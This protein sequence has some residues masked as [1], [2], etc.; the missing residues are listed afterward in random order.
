MP[1]YRDCIVA[2]DPSVRAKARLAKPDGQNK[3]HN[4]TR[5]RL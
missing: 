3:S 1:Y 4:L 2:D 5:M